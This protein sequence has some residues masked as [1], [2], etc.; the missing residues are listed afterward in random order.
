MP[1]IFFY[2]IKAYSPLSSCRF[3]R[4][5]SP[6]FFLQ[7]GFSRHKQLRETLSYQ[8]IGLDC[9][10]LEYSIRRGCTSSIPRGVEKDFLIVVC[11]SRRNSK[12]AMGEG[13]AHSAQFFVLMSLMGARSA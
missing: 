5:I 11:C 4:T 9:P 2:N 8:V 3:C 10:V 7:L 1:A 6:G 13:R 12:A